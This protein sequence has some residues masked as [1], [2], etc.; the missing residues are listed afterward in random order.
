M[1]ML[2][3]LESNLVVCR[4]VQAG[5]IKDLFTAINLQDWF[6]GC[7]I[8]RCLQIGGGASS[9]AG[10]DTV[11]FGAEYP[12]IH[13]D[14]GKLQVNT[15]TIA[16]TQNTGTTGV[17]AQSG[18]VVSTGLTVLN[19]NVGVKAD[20]GALALNG[21]TSTDNNFGVLATGALSPPSYYRSAVEGITTLVQVLLEWAVVSTAG[22][23]HVGNGT[24]TQ[25]ISHRT[26]VKPITSNQVF[27]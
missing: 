1:L 3:I 8:R 25:L 5:A 14:S 7:R 17:F 12:I 16:S 4:L 19:A 11:S 27:R 20:S 18:E 26:L 24:H 21:Y 2:S 10:S 9:I 13:L 6:A 23:M 22:G 15:G